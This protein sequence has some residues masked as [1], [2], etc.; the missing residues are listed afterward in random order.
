M[1][2]KGNDQFNPVTAGNQSAESHV[3][4]ESLGDRIEGVQLENEISSSLPSTQYEVLN[5]ETLLSSHIESEQ[6]ISHLNDSSY[7]QLRIERLKLEILS[8]SNPEINY[9]SD[10]RLSLDQRKQEILTESEREISH[11]NRSTDYQ[12]SLDQLNLR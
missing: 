5:S 2:S 12:S 8:E 7:Y 1:N 6:Q 3:F 10:Y 11:L 4:I 9:S